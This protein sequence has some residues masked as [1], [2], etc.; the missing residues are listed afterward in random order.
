MQDKKVWQ[1]QISL[2]EKKAAA[3]IKELEI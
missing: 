1:S 2:R 3:I